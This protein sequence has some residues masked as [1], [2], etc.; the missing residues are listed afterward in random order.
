MDSITD[1]EWEDISEDP[2]DPTLESLWREDDLLSFGEAG[3]PTIEETKKA[4][5]DLGVVKKINLD[6]IIFQHWQKFWKKGMRTFFRK[7]EKMECQHRD[8]WEKWHFSLST[9]RITEYILP[10]DHFTIAERAIFRAVAATGPE[11]YNLPGPAEWWPDG[12]D[13]EKH[14][15]EVTSDAVLT[16]KHDSAL[17]LV[18]ALNEPEN[19]TEVI[20]FNVNELLIN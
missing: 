20:Q 10:E 18:F 16:R 12:Y 5:E 13:Y 19:V 6:K 4:G 3:M 17:K 8:D 2:F 11:W 9:N 7:L 1:S 14:G 15:W